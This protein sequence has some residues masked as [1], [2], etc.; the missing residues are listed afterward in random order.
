MGAAEWVQE[1][2]NVTSRCRRYVKSSMGKSFDPTP[3]GSQSPSISQVF[4]KNAPDQPLSDDSEGPSEIA[5]NS[6]ADQDLADW[7]RIRDDFRNWFVTV[8]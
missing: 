8:A 4:V 6:Q 3:R 5:T 7:L 1:G 2:A